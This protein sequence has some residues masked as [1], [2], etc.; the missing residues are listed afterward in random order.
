M[1]R[2]LGGRVSV[3]SAWLGLLALSACSGPVISPLAPPPYRDEAPAGYEATWRA[4]VRVLAGENVPLRVVAKDS[5][6]I[7][8]DD[9]V[10]PIGVYADCGRMGEV[11][12]EGDALVSF[13]LFVQPG[14]D[15]NT[16]I[17]V[18]SKMATH[19]YCRGTCGTPKTD[20][21]FQCVSNGRWEA[22]LL[23]SVRRLVKE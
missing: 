16:M 14:R 13:T 8:S 19:G 21:V 9:F 22:N 15:G 4:L 1:P 10:S 18:N 7:A 11:M 17:Q 23:D 12:L 2:S 6:V 3:L 5:G 20:R